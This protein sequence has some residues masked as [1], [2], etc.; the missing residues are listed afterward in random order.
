MKPL[1]LLVF[2]SILIICF[3]CAS[4]SVRDI[5]EMEPFLKNKT[6]ILDE[7]KEAKMMN[8]LAFFDKFFS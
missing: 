5:K 8:Q 3:G 7:K 6:A 2:L 4:V 1:K